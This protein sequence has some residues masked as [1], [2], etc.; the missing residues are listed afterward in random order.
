MECRRLGAG[1]IRAP[2]LKSHRRDAY[3][4]RKRRPALAVGFHSE[5]AEIL[6]IDRSAPLYSSS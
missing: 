2:E 4:R 6:W 3:A 1:A 5:V